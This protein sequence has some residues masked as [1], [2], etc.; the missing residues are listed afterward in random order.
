MIFYSKAGHDLDLLRILAAQS[1]PN[2]N[3]F[4][5][6]DMAMMLF[7]K[8]RLVITVFDSSFYS[9]SEGIAD[10]KLGFLIALDKLGMCFLANSLGSFQ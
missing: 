3:L 7:R 8:G 2:K 4:V 5:V 10:N 6:V 1:K 9:L